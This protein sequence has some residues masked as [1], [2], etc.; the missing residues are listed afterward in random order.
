MAVSE[1]AGANTRAMLVT[2][3]LL[4]ISSGNST[5]S[6][7]ASVACIQRKFLALASISAFIAPKTTSAWGSSSFNSPALAGTVSRTSFPWDW[8]C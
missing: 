1:M 8:I 6:M 7:P 3:T 2:T 4:L 5:F